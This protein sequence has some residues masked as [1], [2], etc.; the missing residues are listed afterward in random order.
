MDMH[1]HL[2][3]LD[4]QIP[5][6]VNDFTNSLLSQHKKTAL[7]IDW[8]FGMASGS[9]SLA[10]CPS[11]CNFLYSASITFVLTSFSLFFVCPF[12]GIPYA[13]PPVGKLR[14][15]PPVTPAHWSGVRSAITPGPVCPQKYPDVSNE[16]AS[17]KNMTPGR[18]SR[19]KRMLPALKNQSEDCLY[20]NIFT[21][22]NG[23]FGCWSVQLTTCTVYTWPDVVSCKKMHLLLF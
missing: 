18:I 2:D 5:V 17:L 19:L 4:S 15:M 10:F 9:A 16:T 20:L 3:T 8:S 11:Q 23:E 6:N 22:A 1:S 14:F 21:P 13:S 12:A 7:S